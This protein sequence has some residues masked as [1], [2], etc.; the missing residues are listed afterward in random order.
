[1][2]HSADDHAERTFLPKSLL[3]RTVIGLFAL[4]TIAWGGQYFGHRLPQIESWIAGLG[5]WAPIA[6][7]L[8]L[9]IGTSFFLPDTLFAIF[10]G[11]IFGLVHGSMLMTVGALLTASLNF[12][13]SRRLFRDRAKDLLDHYPRLASIEKAASNEGLRLL[14]LLRL[15]PISAVAL[16]Y[17]LG[18]SRATYGAFFVSAFAMVPML[19]VEVYF[20]Y[21]ATHLAK[22]AS[23]T[24]STSTLHT[25]VVVL[26]F[27]AC[28]VAM[29]YLTRL[30]T[31]ALSDL[32][33]TNDSKLDGN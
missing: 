27:L 3:L 21:L 13:I 11:A 24:Q 16:S 10:A 1:M 2:P 9:I 8:L 30:A 19:I 6:F 20:G 26:G 18:A 4:A 23:N 25:T 31:N 22:T 15:T 5:I 32:S 28:V 12:W 33:D 17:A 14:V 29:I 7:L